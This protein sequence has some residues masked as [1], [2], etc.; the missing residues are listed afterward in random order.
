ME[1]WVEVASLVFNV[2]IFMA[3]HGRLFYS[4]RQSPLATIA[5]HNRM[6]LQKWCIKVMKDQKDIA[7]IQQLRNSMM[8]SSFLATTSLTVSSVIA[9]FFIRGNSETRIEQLR[10]DTSS[11]FSVETKLFA[12]VI[13]FVASFFCFRQSIRAESYA[14]FMVAI[15]TMHAELGESSEGLISPEYL[16]RLLFRAAMFHSI[17]TRLF[18]AAFLAILWLFG[19]VSSTL[20]TVALLVVLYCTDYPGSSPAK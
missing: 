14:G 15:P 12:M 5:G 20:S 4:I 18:Y 16:A 2:C 17:G 9:A 19:P 8:A 10:D 1:D 11:L 7:A 13:L 6:V 3:Y